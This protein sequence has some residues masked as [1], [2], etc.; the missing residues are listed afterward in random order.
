MS[1]IIR[2][3]K[4]IAWWSEEAFIEVRWLFI[5]FWVSAWWPFFVARPKS[6]MRQTHTLYFKRIH[7]CF[8][9]WR[10]CFTIFKIRCK[11]LYLRCQIAVLRFV[12]NHRW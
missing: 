10:E 11:C 7:V 8:L 1:L 12:H 5:A 2:S 6:T 3:L 9:I 4:A